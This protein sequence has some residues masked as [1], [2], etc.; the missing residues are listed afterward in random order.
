MPKVLKIRRQV[1][2]SARFAKPTQSECSSLGISC[3][4]ILCRVLLG[5]R[6]VG[7]P[8]SEGHRCIYPEQRQ[9]E[10]R[11][12]EQFES[13]PTAA[14]DRPPT[15]L[16]GL[17]EENERLISL[18]EAIQLVIQNADVIRILGGTFANSSGQTV[19]D[20]AITNTQID[21][22]RATF[23]PNLVLNNSYSRNENP[24]GNIDGGAPAGASINA[25]DVDS[26]S[27]GMTVSQQKANGAN[28]SLGVNTNPTR[29]AAPGLALNPQTPS[30]VDLTYTQPLLRGRGVDVNTAPIVIARVNTERSLYQLK[31]TVQE[32]VRSVIDG[33]WG[34]V[35][36]RTD[37]WAR[38]QQV[39]QLDFAFKFL[40]AQRQVGRADIGDT[41]QAEV[42]LASF[43]AALISSKADLINRE[44]AF[45]NVLGL[46]P[47]TR[48][49]LVP[50]TDPVR[51][52]IQPDW[53][54]ILF[55]AE[56]NRP[57]IIDRKLAVEI[58]CQQILIANNNTLPQLDAV[59][60]FGTNALGG[61]APSGNTISSELFQFTDLLL[62]INFSLPVGQRLARANLRQQQLVLA[63]DRAL[64]KQQIHAAQHTLAQNL[65]NLD[66]FYEQYEAFRKVRKASR[67]NVD[68]QLELF[69]IGGL[70]TE[71]VTA[72]QVLQ[73]VTDW[74]NSVSSEASS[75]TQYNS[76]IANLARQTGTIL[77]DHGVYFYE[78]GFDSLGP[79]GRKH[80]CVTY[81]ARTPVGE[82]Q[83]VY[84][85]NGRP[86]EETFNLES[87][88]P[89]MNDNA[90]AP[91]RTPSTG[92]KPRSMLDL[93]PLP[94]REKLLPQKPV[95]PA[96]P[97][98]EPP[99]FEE[100]P[101]PELPEPP[102]VID[103]L[104]ELIPRPLRP[105]NP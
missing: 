44:I 89:K 22:A 41:A 101:E 43:R 37:L 67:V 56:Q 97:A 4:A 86:A 21:Q 87:L 90:S 68:R 15:V 100:P 23:D 96:E 79:W 52:R 13:Y 45:L 77:E 49:R 5:G 91:K 78:E 80:P 82:N 16:N 2:E 18:D 51:D 72:I 17:K 55:T 8:L 25:V 3:W 20:P 6:G 26:Y 48:L 75:L 71:R 30:S 29:V 27:L 24:S 38:Q 31:D 46:P 92:I 40:D 66:T 12:T 10:F 42:S 69:R 103:K 34:L 98:E 62:G 61:R 63:R 104:K 58:D 35:F 1:G 74:G 11:G 64:L 84:G 60:Q 94:D 36:A 88:I 93:E 33:Y 83:N 53:E 54:N 57:D 70:P 81:P 47:N 76:E 95:R 85:N 9:I 102:N 32:M 99:T 39:E 59:T 19:Y 50:S 28:V 7:Q 14:G 65:R 73:A 105:R